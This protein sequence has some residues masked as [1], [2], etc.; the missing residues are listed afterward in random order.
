M[1]DRMSELVQMV[2][3]YEVHGIRDGKTVVLN[4][5]DEFRFY[6][7]DQN[8]KRFKDLEGAEEAARLM[9]VVP[10]VDVRIVQCRQQVGPI[11][12]IDVRIVP[13]RYRHHLTPMMEKMF[14]MFENRWQPGRGGLSDD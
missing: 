14:D 3:W 9:A 10:V 1:G 13:S 5:E 2:R 7:D 12:C 11:D 6:W 4:Y 8:A